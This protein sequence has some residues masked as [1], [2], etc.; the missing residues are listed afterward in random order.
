MALLL[1]LQREMAEIKQKGEEEMRV[2]RLKNED[3]IHSLRLQNKQSMINLKQENEEL[4]RRLLGERIDKTKV[5]SISGRSKVNTPNPEKGDEV[6]YQTRETSNLD[7][8]RHPL[9]DGIINVELLA[10][11]RGL[12][13]DPQTPMNTSTYTPLTLDCSPPMK[14]YCVEFFPIASK[15][16][17]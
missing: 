8:R 13:M 6:S 1:I 4:R 7:E 14:P 11:W 17:L 2:I 15:G 9:V 5:I 10:K 16:W 12:T 3:D